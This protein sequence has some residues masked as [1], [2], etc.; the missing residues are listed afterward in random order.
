MHTLPDDYMTSKVEKPDLNGL[1][2]DINGDEWSAEAAAYND[3][4]GIMCGIG[5][6]GRGGQSGH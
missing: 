2:A 1:F 4:G 6:S 5:G 3:L